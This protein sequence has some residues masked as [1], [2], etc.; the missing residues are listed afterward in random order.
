MKEIPS[1]VNNSETEY[2]ES[3]ENTENAVEQLLNLLSDEKYA[4]GY[5]AIETLNE[6]G[7]I[8]SLEVNA[9]KEARNELKNLI[10]EAAAESLGVSVEDGQ[11]LGREWGQAMNSVTTIEFEGQ[12][13][14]IEKG[15]SELLLDELGH[16]VRQKP[17]FQNSLQE[18]ESILTIKH[19]QAVDNILSMKEQLLSGED[20][21][22]LQAALDA[23]GQAPDENGE[24]GNDGLGFNSGV[25]HYF[26]YRASESKSSRFNREETTFGLDGFK[27]KTLDYV[28]VLTDP[29]QQCVRSSHIF[30]D[31]VGARRMVSL[32]EDNEI[33][34]AFANPGEE[35]KIV[36]VF[37]QKNEKAA[38]KQFNS[39]VDK[40]ISMNVSSDERLNKLGEGRKLDWSKEF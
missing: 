35:L 31:N 13:Y 11:R 34:V 40:E 3:N 9:A 25:V 22:D 20:N 27:Q 6:R 37:S 7:A 32:T 2:K 8:D 24:R 28:D 18:A 19:S 23:W 26:Q 4:E 17:D 38:I 10:S 12:S 15:S 5:A 14:D 1:L 29:S 21:S 30:S 16:R 39:I 36:T 33:I